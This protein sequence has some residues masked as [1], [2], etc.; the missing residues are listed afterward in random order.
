[1]ATTLPRPSGYWYG[2]DRP[3]AVEV[4]EALRRYRTAE[5]AVRRRTRE[6]MGMGEKDVQALRHLMEADRAGEPLTPRMLATKL[7]ISS[8]STTALLDRLARSGHVA[9]RPHPTDRRSLVIVA[10]HEADCE[11]RAT[12]GR[13]HERM[14]AAAARLSPEQAATVVAFLHEMS[15]AVDP[16]DTAA[17]DPHR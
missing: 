14:H 10:T 12:L 1:M 16:E 6:S 15:A 5:Q 13:M 4:L 3:G 2:T 11:I 8:A 9:R 7:G 17:A